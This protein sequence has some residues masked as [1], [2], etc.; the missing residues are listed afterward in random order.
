M[1]CK[2]TIEGDLVHDAFD[3]TSR[4]MKVGIV[5]R[6]CYP[7]EVIPETVGQCC[8]TLK[9]GTNVFKGDRV[10]VKGTKR[11]GIYETT[12]VESR[13]GFTLQ[14][15]KT[16]ANDDACFLAILEVIGSIHD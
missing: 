9:D 14:E 2:E 5:T 11:V 3:G 6:N 7:V 13:Q 4:I 15:N 16:H 1:D 12:I 8:W 10:K